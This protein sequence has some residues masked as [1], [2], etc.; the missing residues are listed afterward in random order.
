MSARRS[1]CLRLVLALA[2]FKL[3]RLL[4][5]RAARSGIHISNTRPLLRPALAV[6]GPHIAFKT[7]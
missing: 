4:V 6:G 7:S 2:I 5:G 1:V 3:S